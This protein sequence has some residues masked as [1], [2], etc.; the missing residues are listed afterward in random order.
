MRTSYAVPLL[1]LSALSGCCASSI[2]RQGALQ[3]APTP[4]QRSAAAA[5][6][7][8]THQRAR[9][10]AVL[11]GGQ[12]ASSAPAT[13]WLRVLL[14]ILFPGNPPRVTLRSNRTEAGVPKKHPS[15]LSCVLNISENR[16][17]AQERAPAPP[18]APPAAPAAAKGKG[19]SKGKS[20]AAIA[21]HSKA[22]FDK[23][24]ASARRRVCQV[25][26]HPRVPWRSS[27]GKLKCGAWPMNLASRVM[28]LSLTR[29]LV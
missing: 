18:P 23:A 3:R 10:L 28:R 6:C 21:V 19:G 26:Q 13:T 11:R 16:S 24:L 9:V 2:E 25:V 14:R 8:A 27:R 1:L 4:Q 15:V 22:E 5:T 29:R 12:T 7:G 17:G 20:G